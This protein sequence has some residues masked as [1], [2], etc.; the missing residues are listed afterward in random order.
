[1]KQSGERLNRK[2]DWYGRSLLKLFQVTLFLDLFSLK[3]CDA[4]TQRRHYQ[5]FH[6][7]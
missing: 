6:L 5:N 7:R 4:E 3:L 1:M 2:N